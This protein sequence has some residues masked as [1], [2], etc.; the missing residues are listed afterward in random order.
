MQLGDLSFKSNVSI[1]VILMTSCF[2]GFNKMALKWY[3]SFI[4]ILE[5]LVI[6]IHTTGIINY[7]AIAVLQMLMMISNLI[8]FQI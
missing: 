3:S 6:L 8:M 7:E 5:Y 2:C 1:F 4:F